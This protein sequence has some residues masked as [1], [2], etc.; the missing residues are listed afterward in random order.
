MANKRK[1][2]NAES[3]KNILDEATPEEGE[4]EVF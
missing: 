3:N 1:L 4:G 2:D